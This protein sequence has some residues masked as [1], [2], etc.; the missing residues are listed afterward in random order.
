MTF[1]I[2]S[3]ELGK[4]YTFNVIAEDGVNHFAAELNLSP[5]AIILKIMG[6]RH[7]GRDFSCGWG[8]ID[9]LT[10]RDLNSTFLLQKLRLV[11]SSSRMIPHRNRSIGF[12]ENVYEVDHVIFSPNNVYQDGIVLS[13]SIH[14]EAIKKWVGNTEKQEE[15]TR[16]YH[17]KEPIFDSPEKLTEFG[18]EMPNYGGVY[19]GYNLSMHS[20]SPGFSSG[21]CFPPSISLVFENPISINASYCKYLEIYSLL[22]LFNG[23]DFAVDLIEV[24]FGSSSFSQAGTIYFPTTNNIP[25]HDQGYPL[26]PLGKN[27]RFDSLGL[28]ELPLESFNYYFSLPD[29]K[30]GYFKKLLTYQRMDNPEE[31][32]LG[33]FRILESLCF[34]KKFF[35]DEDVLEDL[36]KRIKPYLVKRFNDKKSVASFLKGIPRYNGSKYN[37]EKCI[38][39]FYVKVPV[40]ISKNWTVQKSD[41]GSI[42][43]LRNDITHANDYYVSVHEVEEKSKFVEV[44]LILALFESINIDLS[45]SSR[46]IDR[47]SGYHLVTKNV[48]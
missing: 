47:L 42:C 33:F 18:Q 1:G 14:S 45:V 23:N 21:I 43:S 35:L 26:F 38:Q 17:N 8:E 7:E 31:R 44:L 37:T 27:I 10:C 40:E 36:S 9:Q 32:F 25:R 15:I 28:P 6:E 12:F 16:S 29:K 41:I 20:S 11:S 30:R 19:V 24:K 13:L 4:S 22:A 5:E 3:L 46:I 39:D 34:K 48:A 2:K